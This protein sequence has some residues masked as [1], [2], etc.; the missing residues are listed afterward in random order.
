MQHFLSFS[1][2]T[3]NVGFYWGYPLDSATMQLSLEAQRMTFDSSL[4]SNESAL[5]E[6]RCLPCPSAAIDCSSLATVAAP[7]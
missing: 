3:C 2:C 5:S 1:G 6:R 4:G 7:H